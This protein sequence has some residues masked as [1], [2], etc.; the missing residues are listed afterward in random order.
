MTCSESIK[1]HQRA[2][3]IRTITLHEKLQNFLLVI[4]L[5]FPAFSY[6]LEESYGLL[7]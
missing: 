7:P 5:T 2:G 3:V 1:F 4:L 6:E